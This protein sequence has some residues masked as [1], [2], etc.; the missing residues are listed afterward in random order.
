M[1]RLSLWV[2]SA[3]APRRDTLP[4]LGDFNA[5][6]GTDRDGYETC[7][8]PHGSATVNQNITKFLDIERSHGLRVARS[9]FQHPQAHHWTWHS[10]A[11]GVEK[12][13]DH[14]LVDGRRRTIHNCR[15]NR[16]AQFLNTDYRLVGT[17]SEVAA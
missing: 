15:V 3:P 10:N 16:S 11:G 5:S 9:W 17:N 14:V 8:G 12:E 7:I 1:P 4:V 6:N 2:I 13:I